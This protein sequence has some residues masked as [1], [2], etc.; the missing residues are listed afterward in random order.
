MPTNCLNPK[1][2]YEDDNIFVI[3][4]PAG[5]IVNQ[6]E[7]VIN[8]QTIQDWT[9]SKL[10]KEINK[11]RD[12]DFAKRSGIIHR[13]DK[14][15]SGILLIAKN[16]SS[17]AFLQMQFKNRKVKKKYIALV[18]G[19]VSPKN[20][21]I[22]API[23]RLPWNRERFG[24][25]PQGREAVTKYQV[26]NTYKKDKECY[27]LLEVTPYTGRTH[28]IRVHCKYIGFPVVGDSHYAGRKVSRNDRKILPRQFLHASNI[29][30]THPKTGKIITFFSPLP[31][32]LQKTLQ[33]LTKTS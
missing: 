31:Q 28:Q 18:H 26:I 25:I 1:I 11:E 6:A 22:N 32:D 15:T 23:A 12:T 7:T 9:S 16:Q 27:S 13:L 4:K 24:I 3:E 2:L 5:I 10:I 8:Q 19:L 29:E 20:G 21:T 14:E 33:I 30:I 17:F